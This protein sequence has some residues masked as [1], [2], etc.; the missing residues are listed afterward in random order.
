MQKSEVLAKFREF[1]NLVENR[2]GLKGKT[3]E[4]GEP[5]SEALTV[6]QRQ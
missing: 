5:H 1:I 4:L 2:T 3:I 6:R